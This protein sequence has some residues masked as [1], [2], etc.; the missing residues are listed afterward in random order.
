MINPNN[1]ARNQM[2]QHGTPASLVNIRTNPKCG[3]AVVPASLDLV[4]QTAAQDIDDVTRPERGA[5]PTGL[6]NAGDR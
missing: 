1:S 5:S 4:G 3:Q 6:L 2:A